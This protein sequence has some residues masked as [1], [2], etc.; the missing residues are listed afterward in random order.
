[1]FEKAGVLGCKM[2]AFFVECSFLNVFFQKTIYKTV[3][4]CYTV[5][6][7]WM[8]DSETIGGHHVFF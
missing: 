1:M 8:A 4:L 2:P 7:V 5:D 6:D 3:F